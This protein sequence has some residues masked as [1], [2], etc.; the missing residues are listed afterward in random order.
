M[1]LH[2]LDVIVLNQ[3]ARSDYDVELTR[4]GYG[5]NLI[6]NPSHHLLH[7]YYA[8]VAADFDDAA[9]MV[10]DGAGYSFGE[11]Q[12]RGS[13]D[14]GRRRLSRRWKKPNRSTAWSIG[15]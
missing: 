7:A 14:L 8:W 3:Y 6:T 12:R 9:I 13:S 4:L 5:S 2:L 1:G 10:L 15:S 11:Y